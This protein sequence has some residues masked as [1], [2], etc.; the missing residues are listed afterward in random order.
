MSHLRN[1]L[2]ARIPK[3]RE[4]VRNLVSQHGDE[5]VSTISIAQLFK[6]LRSVEAIVCNTSYV[7][8]GEGLFIR[9]YPLEQLVELSGEQIFHLLCTSEIPPEAAELELRQELHKRSQ[10]PDYVYKLLQTVPDNTH[11][12]TLLSLATLAMQ[13]ESVFMQRY[14]EGMDRG[15]HWEATLEDALNIIARLP[16]IAA[17]IYRQ[18]IQKKAAIPP[19]SGLSYAENFA[20]MLGIDDPNGLFGQFMRRFIVVHSDHEGANASVL[21]SRVVDS[22]LSDLYYSIS[23]SMNSLAGPLHGL[24]NQ[25]SVV[26]AQKL[27][28]HFGGIPDVK[29][30]DKYLWQYLQSGNVIPGFGHAVLRKQDPRYVAVFEFGK[31]IFAE[32]PLFRIAELLG[33]IVPPLLRKQGKAKNPYPNIDGISGTLLYN[34]GV[35][36]MEFYT[37]M[38]SVSQILGICAQLIMNRA[39]NSPLIRPKSVTTRWLQG[40]VS[41]VI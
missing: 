8:P 31:S 41:D 32:D 34:F 1:T 13:R 15:D 6:G 36:E 11:P 38:F 25:H 19:A 30:L 10:I 23:A 37:V 7:D 29:S 14:Q 3:L 28:A 4:E 24:A 17:F 20:Q 21:T 22:S 16:V 26:F 40:H 9:G 35:K 33:E 12:M 39:I 5:I 27:L 18:V 2:A